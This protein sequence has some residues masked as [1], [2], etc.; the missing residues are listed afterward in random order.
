MSNI[1]AYYIHIYDDFYITF[2]SLCIEIILSHFHLII[3]SSFAW[4]NMY[5]LTVNSLLAKNFTL[6]E[7]E[8]Y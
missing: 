6:E 3:I 2:G 8:Y 1:S 4:E 5:S 7:F